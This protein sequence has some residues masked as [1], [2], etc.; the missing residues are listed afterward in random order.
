MSER[1]KRDARRRIHRAAQ[2][3]NDAE[4]ELEDA[5]LVS[6]VFL[7]EWSDPA[8]QRWM[9]RLSGSADGAESP[10]IWQAQGLLYHALYDWPAED[11]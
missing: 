1:G 9:T 3:T 4:P 8:G 6:W 2:L 5:Y 7:A 10:P 11:D